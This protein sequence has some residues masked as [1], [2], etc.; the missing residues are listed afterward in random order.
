MGAIARYVTHYLQHYYR[1]DTAVQQ[2]PYLQ[3]WSAELGDPLDAH[4]TT[5]FPQ[6]P[7]WLPKEIAVQA[8]LESESL[9]FYP[10]VPGFPKAG[11]LSTLQQVID[12][13]TQIIFT[14]G[15]Q[16]AAVNFSQFDYVGYAPNAPFAAYCRP[17][18][19]TSLEQLLPSPEQELGQIELAFALS[20]IRWGKLGS[21]E[22]IPFSDVSDRQAL[23]QF[24]SDLAAIEREINTRNQRRLETSGIQ[25]P[26]L[27]PSRIPNSINI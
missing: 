18:V 11:E 17:D 21:S 27:L 15:P 24:Q 5:E 8:G 7:S 19:C 1:D 6:V 20:G 14:C 10:R 3:A 4:P 9:P 12:I 2:D 26:Y 22:L 13:A 25:Y 16:H 23:E